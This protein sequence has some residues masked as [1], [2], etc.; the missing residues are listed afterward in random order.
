VCGL[1]PHGHVAKREQQSE[2]GVDHLEVAHTRSLAPCAAVGSSPAAAVRCLCG[3]PLGFGFVSILNVICAGI[4]GSGFTYGLTWVREQRRTH[5][6]Y[7]APQRVAIGDIVAATY[8]LTLRVYAFRNVTEELAKESEGK[9]FRK[10]SGAEIHEVSDQA[11]RAVLGV[12]RAFHVGRLTIV[13]AECYGAMGDAFNNFAKL[14][15]ALRGVGELTPTAD[16]MRAKTTS[17]VSSTEVLN[18]DVVALVG[19]GQKHLSPVQTWRNKRRREEVHKRL[20]AKYFEPS[21]KLT[22]A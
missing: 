12:G 21:Q 13:D 8:E 14:Q 22:G 17:V 20:E 19:A 6:A 7:R 10:I 16:N 4:A 1:L 3:T 9:K 5:D 2:F 18:R 11:N 15:T